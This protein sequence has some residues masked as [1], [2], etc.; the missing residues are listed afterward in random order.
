MA[1]KAL[2][3]AY[4]DIVQDAGNRY[5]PDLSIGEYAVAHGARECL[6]VSI[7]AFHHYS[8]CC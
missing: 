2:I 4:T 6:K 7:Q 8:G 5:G 1:E 3:S